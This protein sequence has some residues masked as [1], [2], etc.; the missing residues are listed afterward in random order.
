MLDYLSNFTL[1]FS[2]LFIAS[3]SGLAS[4]RAGIINIGINGMMII[5]ALS[6][7]L[8]G[9]FMGNKSN[10][11]QILAILLTMI[12][13]GFFS[14]LHAFACIKLK[15]NQIISG[16]AIN[17]LASGLGLF[18]VAIPEITS[19]SEIFT[20]F[21]LISLDSKNGILS[22]FFFIAL[23]LFVLLYIFFNKTRLGM[24]YKA[25]GENPHAAYALGIKVIKI[26]YFAV[27]LSG[28]L[29]GL[30]GS[31]FTFYNSNAFSGNVKGEGYIALAILISGQWKVEFIIISSI[32]FSLLLSFADYIPT[33]PNISQSIS[34]N[35][36]LF[37][38]LPFIITILSMIIFAKNSQ[39]PKAL[40]IPFNSSER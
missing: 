13:T 7:S 37:S 9:H 16:I 33:D 1:V 31:M 4:E 28:C 14:L 32:V 15:A 22:L 24:R 5:G 20:N 38:T 12:I 34:N 21:T 30:A 3:L 17:V 36:I 19:G 23:F 27:I 8:L 29:A 26:K 18:F 35:S 39:V 10:Y 40:G 25:I 11:L 2:I 6:F